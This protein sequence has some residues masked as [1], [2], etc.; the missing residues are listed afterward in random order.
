MELRQLAVLRAIAE[1]R[2]FTRAG[3]RVG[4]TQSAVSQQVKALEAE[5]G[6]PLLVR[7]SK[8]VEISRAGEL[9]LASAEK[10]FNELEVVRAAFKG[11]ETLAASRLRVA[12]A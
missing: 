5:L 11:S 10:I 9:V 2:N 12:M 3:E 8:R 4:L 1:T 7:T 6:E